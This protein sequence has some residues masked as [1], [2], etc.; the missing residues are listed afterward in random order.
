M[1]DEYSRKVNSVNKNHYCKEIGDII[2]V[3]K[4]GYEDSRLMSKSDMKNY[5]TTFIDWSLLRECW[6][7]MRIGKLNYEDS[8]DQRG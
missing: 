5:G 8:Y 3:N 1:V 4:V 2:K 7:F 6:P